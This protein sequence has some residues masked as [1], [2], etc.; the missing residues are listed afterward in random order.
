MKGSTEQV[1][2]S[3]EDRYTRGARVQGSRGQDRQHDRK[4][5]S[6]DFNKYRAQ[7]RKQNA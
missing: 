6:P 3:Q 4:H 1:T 5:N 7:P 2:R